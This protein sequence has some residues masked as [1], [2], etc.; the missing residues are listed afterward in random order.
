MYHSSYIIVGSK[1]H[2]NKQKV[3]KGKTTN[4]KGKNIKK[5]KGRQ[6]EASF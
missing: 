4:K 5:Y 6:E 2:K 1:I 3:E